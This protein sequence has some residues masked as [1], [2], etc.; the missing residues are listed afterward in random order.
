MESAQRGSSWRL[1]WKII[2]GTHALEEMVA[3]ITAPSDVLLHQT[4][5]DVKRL[6]RKGNQ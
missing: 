2:E 1:T 4:Q 3:A 6:A 5:A